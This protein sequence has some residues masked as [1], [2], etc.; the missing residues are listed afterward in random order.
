MARLIEL[1]ERPSTATDGKVWLNA[2]KIVKMTRGGD[3]RVTR[4]EHEPYDA[5]TQ[6][7]DYTDV[8]ETPEEIAEMTNAHLRVD[9]NC[10]IGGE[11]FIKVR[12]T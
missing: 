10:E 12:Q 8:E 6:S 3:G 4:V 11:S 5:E 1:T 9:A 7:L 2:D